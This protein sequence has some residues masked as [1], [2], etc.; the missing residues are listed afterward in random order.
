MWVKVDRR[1]EGCG[2]LCGLRLRGGARVKKVPY[3]LW[4]WLPLKKFLKSFGFC[5]DNPP[6][7]S[8]L[9]TMSKVKLFFSVGLSLKVAKV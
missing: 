2:V 7:P 1:G 8:L 6:P 5:W 9:W 4:N 3:K